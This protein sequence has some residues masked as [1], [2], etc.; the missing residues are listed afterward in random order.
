MTETRFRQAF[1]L[2]LVAAITAAFVAM[3]REFLLTILLAA[4]FA[5]LSYPVYR[6]VLGRVHGRQGLASIATLLL[7]L[8]L[9][10][11]PLLAVLGAGAREALRVTETIRPRLQQL[12]AQPGEF[13]RRLRALPGY[14]R[15]EPYRA[16]IL[17]KAGELVGGTSAFL[18]AALS[19]TTVAT[20]LFMFH[21]FV[22][23]YTMYFFLTGGPGLLAGIL[24]YLPLTEADKQ[25]MVGKFVS[26][27]RATLKGTILIG[28]AQGFL[29]GLAF[30]AA[31]I[32]GAIFWG[33]VMT[34][35]SIIPGIGGALVWVPAAIVLMATGQIWQGIALAL[36]CALIIGSVDNVL[37]PLLVGQDIKMH[38]LLIFFS[39]LGGLMFFGAM[40][41]ILGPILAALFVTA[42]EM[43]GTAFRT[44]LAEP[45]SA[46]ADPDLPS[47]GLTRGGHAR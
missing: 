34:V 5:G 29:G 24:A 46:A 4:I 42:W 7:L 13:D 40:G 45:G 11:A 33:T 19:A 3:I 15:I 20:A 2:L 44:V 12:I 43:F 38:E 6:W 1:L 37:R 32:D 25:R 8:A 28:A 31:G 14:H 47:A 10:M 18:F 26:V 17:T 36:F 30:W 39:T 9:V 16:Q 35:L 21:F 22:L 27:T 23:L 41:F